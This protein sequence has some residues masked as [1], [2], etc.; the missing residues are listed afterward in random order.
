[1]KIEHMEKAIREI[2]NKNSA[3]I[4]MKRFSEYRFSEA[5]GISGQIV[6]MA[7]MVDEFFHEEM[8]LITYEKRQM[9]KKN[10]S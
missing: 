6:D 2:I 1:M 10:H 4:A 7:N 9:E 5:R 3:E 8:Q